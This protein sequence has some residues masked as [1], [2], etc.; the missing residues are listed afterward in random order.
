MRISFSD[1]CSRASKHIYTALSELNIGKMQIKR[2]SVWNLV[3]K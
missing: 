1:C 2:T 3:W